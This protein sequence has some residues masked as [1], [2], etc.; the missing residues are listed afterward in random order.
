MPE[1]SVQSEPSANTSVVKKNVSITLKSCLVWMFCAGLFFFTTE[2]IR[3]A[4]RVLNYSNIKLDPLEDLIESPTREHDQ[5]R[6]QERTSDNHVPTKNIP[7]NAHRNV[8]GGTN[9][10]QQK[11]RSTS[12]SSKINAKVTKPVKGDQVSKTTQEGVEIRRRLKMGGGMGMGMGGRGRGGRDNVFL[13]GRIRP[14][15][16][17]NGDYSQ[18]NP[19]RVMTNVQIFQPGQ[20][21]LDPGTPIILAPA[22]RRMRGMGKG[23]MMGGSKGMGGNSKSAVFDTFAPTFPPPPVQTLFPTFRP[24]PTGAPSSMPSQVPS[25]LPSL[26]VK[27]SSMPSQVPSLAPSLS[28]KPSARPPN[29]APSTIGPTTKVTTATTTAAPA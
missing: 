28:I 26:S 12:F 29:A 2:S 4:G 15:L 20:G 23:G 18:R 13:N 8:L 27:P 6:Q 5:P 3:Y 22:G 1:T 16:P 19:V 10:N 24:L 11:E 9:K 17:P 21:F 25:N 14:R 7:E